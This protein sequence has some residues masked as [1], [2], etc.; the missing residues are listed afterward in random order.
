M[1]CV[2]CYTQRC[3][4]RPQPGFSCEMI[5]CPAACT[6]VFHSCKADEHKLVCLLMKVPCLNNNYGCRATVARN[7]MHSHLEVC[8]A[9]VVCCTMEWNRWPVSS[10][11]YTSYESLS[12]GVEE[13]EQLDMALAL[14]DQCTLLESLKVIA[15][16]PTVGG[17]Q[18]V[19]VRKEDRPT[20]FDLLG[21][22]CETAVIEPSSLSSSSSSRQPQ[23]STKD[24]AK[25]RIASG[26]NGLNEEHFS[27]L[28]EA[29]VE[30][31]RSLVAALEIV[32]GANSAESSAGRTKIAIARQSNCGGNH[33]N[34]NGGPI[35]ATMEEQR[36]TGSTREDKVDCEIFNA[37]TEPVSSE[38]RTL[39][40]EVG[41]DECEDTA[42]LN[43]SP[44]K[45]CPGVA[46]RAQRVTLED[47]TCGCHRNHLPLSAQTGFRSSGE[48]QDKWTDTSD[49]ER[50]ND[51][52][53]GE[54]DAISAALLFCLE[55]SRERTRISDA[56]RA[57]G[58]R[59]FATQTFTFP[60]AILLT[61]TRVGD[62]ASASACDHAAAASTAYPS[63]PSPFHSLRLGLV[64][65]ALE[66]EAVP[67]GRHLPADP[68]YRHVFP[69]VCGQPLR[70]DQFSAHF[71][72]VHG[73]IHAALNGW[74]EQRCPLAYYGCTFSQ[75]R[76]Y[77]CTPGARVVHS[78]HLRAF[79]V[80]P[81]PSAG[82]L[83]TA[84]RSDRFSE[85]P[86]EVLRHI[87]RYLDSFSLCQLS[88]VS[89]TLREVCASLLE[90]RGIVELQWERTQRPS[91]P[92]AV[93]WQV[94]RKVS[95]NILIH[96]FGKNREASI[97][98]SGT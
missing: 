1:H 28:Y 16:T 82:P 57:N 84:C 21:S 32:S 34:W 86:S 80:Q 83:G 79:G 78:R 9:G 65:E 12:R 49:L 42:A 69:F 14:Q 17:A 23:T 94:K 4:V 45:L 51:D 88:L 25:K 52:S 63:Q 22:G 72:N 13:A 33:D 20:N 56:V 7:Q 68:R 58:R 74:M 92:A 19:P 87:A 95:R 6:A 50:D 66:V 55:E 73:D 38:T 37:S 96:H 75:R 43:G 10:L 5:P 39:C 46:H 27:K 18:G 2:S 15:M 76:F 62:V 30:T 3:T 60:A 40:Q 59:N 77:P 85:L 29:T 53:G 91:D 31:A 64:L 97:P 71:T 70:R 93:R 89:W 11:D 90:S 41:Q 24:S 36:H 61:G 81:C 98:V 44:A 8:P 48:R 35:E 67:H 54:V 47:T 26:I